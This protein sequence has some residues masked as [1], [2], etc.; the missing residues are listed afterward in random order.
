M[1]QR[2]WAIL[3]QP[4]QRP[5]GAWTL[6]LG[7]MTSCLLIFSAWI[8]PP[9]RFELIIQHDPQEGEV[10]SN[11]IMCVG[12]GLLTGYIITL[13]M[14]VLPRILGRVWMCAWVFVALI[15]LIVDAGCLGMLR[16]TFSRGFVEIMGGT[17]GEEVSGFIENYFHIDF[18]WWL[19]G[20]LAMSAVA[21]VIGRRLLPR[22]V[23]ADVT[24]GCLGLMM[25]STLVLWVNDCEWMTGLSYK[26]GSLFNRF[27]AESIIPANP[28][29]ERTRPA[30]EAPEL[31]VVVFG[32]SLTASH[33]QLYGYE[34]E[35]QPRMQALVGSGYM[36]VMGPGRSAGM[37]T[38]DAFRQHMSTYGTEGSSSEAWNTAPNIIE[39]ARLAGY[40]TVWFSNQKRAGRYEN[41]ISRFA[42]F[43]DES[44]FTD[45][46]VL[47][48]AIDA[49]NLWDERLLPL[50]AE[51]LPPAGEKSMLMIHLMGSHPAYSGR[52]NHD[53]NH[54]TSADYASYPEHQRDKLRHYDNSVLYN[55]WIIDEIIRLTNGRKAMLLYFS[56]HG[57]DLYESDADYAGH[58]RDN[59]ESQQ[60][61]TRVPLLIYTSPELRQSAPE[62]QRRIDGASPHQWYNTTNI[63]Y[64]VN[65]ILGQRFADR[66]NGPSLLDQ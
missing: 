55:D 10:L 66:P 33:C 40:H 34:K 36:R 35:T 16:R 20:G 42:Q 52:Y 37:H 26:I 14:C 11:C 5:W 46:D 64:T 27:R 17:N 18:I 56:D 63:I 38:V 44:Y 58:A 32:E 43:A 65:D 4:L 7:V 57:S 19:L 31:L 45:E 61:G 1:R 21:W 23:N 22:H 6:V 62:L 51:H 30:D 54:F 41:V 48:L 47:T 39:V 3:A 9:G 50:V 13:V 12:N 2:I 49:G 25:C 24:L 53:F 8:Y 60:M 28:A 29:L 59:A 15:D